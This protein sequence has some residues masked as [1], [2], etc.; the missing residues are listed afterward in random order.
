MVRMPAMYVCQVSLL[1][2]GAVAQSVDHL[3]IGPRSV[4]LYWRGFESQLRHKAIEKNPCRAIRQTA[5][6]ELNTQIGSVAKKVS[7]WGGRG[8]NPSPSATHPSQRVPV[9]EVVVVKL[10]RRRRPPVLVQPDVEVAPVEARRGHVL[11][12]QTVRSRLAEL[13]KDQLPSFSQ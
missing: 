4:Q 9:T 11:E 1:T 2:R 8:S 12:G 10:R 13:A 7:F 5:K 6:L 3:S